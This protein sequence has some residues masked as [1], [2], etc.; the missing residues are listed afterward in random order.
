MKVS[1]QESG[2]LYEIT[3]E[4]GAVKLL[5]FST[6]KSY[7]FKEAYEAIWMTIELIRNHSFDFIIEDDLNKIAQRAHL[8]LSGIPRS[9]IA[10]LKREKINRTY[11]DQFF[12]KMLSLYR[13]GNEAI[14]VSNKTNFIIDHEISFLLRRSFASNLAAQTVRV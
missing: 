14:A 4:N 12:L 9:L 13:S 6:S 10:L 7:T 8:S 5:D 11:Y 1:H 2:I 3:E